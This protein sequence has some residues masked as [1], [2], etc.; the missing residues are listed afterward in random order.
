MLSFF[1][2]EDSLCILKDDGPG[3]RDWGGS[4]LA[5]LSVLFNVVPCVLTCVIAGAVV[6]I[7]DAVNVGCCF[8]CVC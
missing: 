5:E 1:G 6:L 2:I 4:A 8:C 3:V 7:V